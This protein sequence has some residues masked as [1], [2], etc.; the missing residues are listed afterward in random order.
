MHGEVIQAAFRPPWWL[1]GPHRQTLWGAF[2][3]APPP[4]ARAETFTLPDGDFLRLF[5]SDAPEP[6][7]GEP[8]VVLLHGLAGSSESPYVRGIA[9]ELQQRGVLSV[10]VN[11]RG[12]GGVPNHRARAYHSG[13]TGD[14]EALLAELQGRYP[15]RLLRVVGTSLG[16]NVLLCH[17]GQSGDE[18]L[19]DRAVAICPPVDLVRCNRSLSQGLSWGYHLYLLRCLKR[20]ARLKLSL[21]REAG[22]DVDA[23]LRTRTFNAYDDLLTAPMF[24]YR[25][26]ADYYQRASSRPLLKNICRPTTV[27]F[28]KDDP[29]MHPS[30]VPAP[31]EL[32]PQVRFEVSERGGH[33]GFVSGR[34]RYWLDERVPQLILD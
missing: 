10:A 3:K 9:W 8:L 5:W 16:G 12:C 24:G 1:A 15:G 19:V 18:T 6:G 28:A 13:E 17:L 21:L 34:G 7:P 22:V 20:D 29:F 14:L 27:L 2:R 33:V 11:F 4:L 32:A 25:D 30:M 23:L 26:A 31:E